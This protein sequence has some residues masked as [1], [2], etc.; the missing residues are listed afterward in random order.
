MFSCF[1]ARAEGCFCHWHTRVV[2]SDRLEYLLLLDGLDNDT[3][4]AASRVALNLVEVDMA[5][6]QTDIPWSTRD[7][8]PAEAVKAAARL[9]DRFV[10]EQDRQKPYMMTDVTSTED[11]GTRDDFIAV[12]PHAYDATFWRSDYA[13]VASLADEGSCLAIWLADEDRETIAELI[14]ADRVV[15]LAEWNRSHPSL[16]RTF[17]AG[18]NTPGD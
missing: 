12:A 18:P 16:W 13:E 3:L 7:T 1:R 6:A 8:W 15:A 4:W 10:P 5:T 2:P 14:G 11:P 17:L 9:R